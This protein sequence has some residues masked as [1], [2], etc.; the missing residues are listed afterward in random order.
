MHSAGG[1]IAP[2]GLKG[3]LAPDL[4]KAGKAG[5]VTGLVYITAPCM[6]VGEEAPPAPWFSYEV[7]SCKF[8]DS[9]YGLQ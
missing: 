6:S 7:G 9:K 1:I 2:E 4:A 5:G 8:S 3:L